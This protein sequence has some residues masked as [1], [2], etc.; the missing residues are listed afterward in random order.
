MDKYTNPGQLMEKYPTCF[1]VS[2]LDGIV[3]QTPDELASFLLEKTK[4][5]LG[6]SSD[7]LLLPVPN[8]TKGCQVEIVHP[9]FECLCPKTG[10]PDQASLTIKYTPDE[11]IAELKAFK[12]FC[13]KFRNIGIFHENLTY[14]LGTLFMQEI[15][16]VYLDITGNFNAR[17]G[18]RTNVYYSNGKVVK[19]E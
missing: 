18:I 9:E 12:L 19:G 16:P 15:S 17:G 8:F 1:A 2:H 10:L 5:E 11:K 6:N 7:Q 13:T 14:F 3:F 4:E